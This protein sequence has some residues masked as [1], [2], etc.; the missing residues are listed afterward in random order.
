MSNVQGNLTLSLITMFFLVS[1]LFGLMHYWNEAASVQD[2]ADGLG[3]KDTS[4]IIDKN[5]DS[6]FFSGITGLFTSSVIDY[7][8]NALS[9]ASP[10]F[11]VK[12]IIY[13]FTIS[14]PEIYKF[15]DLF[16]LRPIGWIIFFIQFEWI[17]YYV[18]GK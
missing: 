10:F 18:R 14:T 5:E 16:F 1:T 7:I 4:S 11:I 3:V 2:Q 6:G 13:I 12:G 15:V 17:A 9:W 8:A